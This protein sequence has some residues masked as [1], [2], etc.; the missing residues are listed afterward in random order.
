[1][2]LDRLVDGCK[3][4][5]WDEIL[6][7]PKWQIHVF[8][9]KDSHYLALLETTR[10]LDKIREY[11]GSPIT[12]TSGYRPKKYNALIGGA[13]LSFHQYG[14]ALD[15]VVKGHSTDEVKKELIPMLR[16]LNIRLEDNGDGAG[17]LHMDLGQPSS[18]KRRFF[19]P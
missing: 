5:R 6:Y 3:Y 4:F 11:F 1:M 16:D 2:D 19:K 13:F 9:E 8:P 12:I 18:E 15:F 7:C 10:A 14:M 17:W